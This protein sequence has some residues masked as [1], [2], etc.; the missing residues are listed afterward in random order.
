N[1]AQTIS[2][3]KTFTAATTQIGAGVNMST[4]SAGNLNV[5]GTVTAAN[6]VGNASGLTGITSTVSVNSPITGNGSSGSPLSLDASS[7][8]L[9]GHSST[10][11]NNPAP[12]EA[13]PRL[14]AVDG[15][16]LLNISSLAVNSVTPSAV[17]AGTYGISITGTAGSITGNINANQINAGLLPSNVIA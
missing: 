15:S 11:R 16:Q 13:P 17:S 5:P 12:R 7:V 6:F 1:A 3:A 9:R 8:T 2:G 14:P 10:L 4:F